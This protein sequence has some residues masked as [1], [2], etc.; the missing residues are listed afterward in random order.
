MAFGYEGETEWV[1]SED[2]WQLGRVF[3]I[4]I[5]TVQDDN[6]FS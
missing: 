2:S 3:Q 6:K 1:V 4:L 5:E